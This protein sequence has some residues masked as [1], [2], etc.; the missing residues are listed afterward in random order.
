MQTSEALQL[1]NASVRELSAYDL[2]PETVPVKVN[3]NENPYDWPRVVK[4]KAAEYCLSRP[5]NRYPNFTPAQLTA[6]LAEYA[7]VEPESVLAGNGSNE[8]LVVLFMA[9]LRREYPVI[10]CQPTFTVYNL[11]VRALGGT[12]ETVYL[13][14]D[15]AFD[16]DAIRQAVQIHRG[17]LLLLCSPNNPTGSALTEAQLRG[18]LAVHEGFL[19]LDQAYVEFGGYDATGLLEQYPN[20]IITRTCSKAFGCAGLR[21]GYMVGNPQVVAEAKKAKLPYNINFF[22]EFVITMLLEHRD[23]MARHVEGLLSARRSLVEFLETLPLER[24]Y[25][26]EANFVLLRTSEKQRLFEFLRQRG[27]LIRDVS[28]YPMLDNCLRI[29]VGTD[30]ENDLLKQNLRTF[31]ED[32]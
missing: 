8:M 32:D 29:S 31:F 15:M 22:S 27:I 16:T 13:T 25:P 23:E 5:W 14:R 20:L 17:A 30:Q 10:L 19:I 2:K 24:V 26:S 11:L 9:L 7:G 6:A 12:T 3:Q 4:E 1:M 18:I 21:L 28:S